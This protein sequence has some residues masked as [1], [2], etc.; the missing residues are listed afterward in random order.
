MSE[1][2]GFGFADCS[3]NGMM[4]MSFGAHFETQAAGV[5]Q[6][7]FCLVVSVVVGMDLDVLDDGCCF[8]A[9]Y[10]LGLHDLWSLSQSFV[11]LRRGN[12]SVLSFYFVAL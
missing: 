3:L 7:D 9:P 8:I 10:K 4:H 2:R 11:P 1:R 5:S 6:L 12:G